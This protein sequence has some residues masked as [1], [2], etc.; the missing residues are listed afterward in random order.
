MG[1]HPISPAAMALAGK[2]EVP[3][4]P[5]ATL[6]CWVITCAQVRELVGCSS[7]RQT[8]GIMLPL[9]GYDGPW[10]VATVVRQQRA[11]HR[12]GYPSFAACHGRICGYRVN[13]EFMHF[14]RP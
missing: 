5:M 11:L 8:D 13:N 14:S 4:N 10:L 3:S 2:S 12:S 1:C 9:H 7:A 6:V